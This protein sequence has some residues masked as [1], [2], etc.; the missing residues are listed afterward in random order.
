MPLPPAEVPAA[1]RDAWTSIVGDAHVVEDAR[2]R[3]A[4]ATATFETRTR[5]PLIV[6]PGTRAEVQACVRVAHT[7][8]IPLYPVSSGLNWGY[9]SAVPASDGNV[10]L[11]LGRLRRI[12]DF[13]ETLGYVTVEP[14]V[15]QQQLFDFLRARGSQLWMDA[16]GTSPKASLV[17]N[18]ME[19]GFGHTPYGDHFAHVC[20]LEVVLGDGTC[21]DTGFA[22]FGQ[23]VTAPV[24]RWGLGPVLD[25]LFTQSNLGIVT[26]MTIWLMPAPERFQAFFFRCDAP[27]DLGRVIDALRPLKLSGTLRSAVHIGNDYK[28]L[29]GLQQYP[30]AEMQGRTPLEPADMVAFRARLRIGLWN[31]SGGLYGTAAQVAEARRLVRRALKGIASQVQFLDDRLLAL[32]QRFAGPYRLVTGWDLSATLELLAPVYGL[33]RGVPTAQ[34]LAS[35]YWRKRTLPPAD[36][37]PD[38]DR[39]GLLWCAPVAPMEGGHAERLALI[40]SEVLL[41]HGFEPLISIT[42][43]TDRAITCVVSISYDRDVAGEDSRAMTCY[44]ALLDALSG[45]GYHSY[46]LGI[47]AMGK[48]WL[49]DSATPLLQR[50]KHACDPAGILA[51]GRYGLGASND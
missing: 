19:R 28:V 48:P 45:A 16:T 43:V 30:W 23:T 49:T 6:R 27:G 37:N 42:L 47:Q 7:H 4:A 50:L 41:R 33:M 21:I 22:R 25:G 17:G 13:N 1:A 5:V 36:M 44:H 38:R 29:N 18:T 32:A 14:G 20:A 31:G 35:A 8:G 12:V 9:G 3:T 39:C 2:A 40:S 10:V 15:T 24:Y 26:R 11:D 51:P 46:R 34:P